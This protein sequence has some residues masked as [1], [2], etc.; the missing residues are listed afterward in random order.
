MR[1]LD[2][3]REIARKLDTKA[4]LKD[5]RENRDRI[6]QIELTGTQGFQQFAKRVDVQLEVLA[7][8]RRRTEA[9]NPERLVAEHYDMQKAIDDLQAREAA[10]EAKVA[11]VN[12]VAAER[13]W[14]IA[15]VMTLVGVG[16]GVIG[17]LLAHAF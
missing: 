1:A 9:R 16:S 4:D 11:Q 12:A 14:V 3:L 15:A 6:T 8:F 10:L 5:M 7:E 13:K 17:V 2:E